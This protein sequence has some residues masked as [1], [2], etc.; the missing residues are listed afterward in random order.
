V[1]E[2]VRD[3]MLNWA[4]TGMSVMESSHRAKPFEA[5]LQGAKARMTELLGIPDGYQI[6]F[7]GGGAVMAWFAYQDYLVSKSVV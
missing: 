4:G 3:E 5:M 2:R 6:L 7:V 1:L